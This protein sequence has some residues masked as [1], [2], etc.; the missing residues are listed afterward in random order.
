MSFRNEVRFKVTRPELNTLYLVHDTYFNEPAISDN[1]VQN[2]VVY[3]LHDF[4][5]YL[6]K[7]VM[8]DPQKMYTIKMNAATYTAFDVFYKNLGF[9]KTVP[10][11]MRNM[12]TID[13]I[14]GFIDLHKKQMMVYGNYN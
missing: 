10:E 8:K 5:K 1:P 4:N 14:L 7:V 9:D 6:L 11:Q 2:L 12:L 13:E 3:V